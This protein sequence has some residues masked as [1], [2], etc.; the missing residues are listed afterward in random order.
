MYNDNLINNN[1]NG[2]YMNSRLK[3][4][5]YVVILLFLIILISLFNIMI[6]RH[7]EY[8]NAFDSIVASEIQGS[9]A[10]RGR[11]YDRNNKLLVDNTGIKSIYYK[12]ELGTSYEIN[13]AH[14]LSLVLEL[15]YN[16]VTDSMLKDLYLTSKHDE[17][18]TEEEFRM[19]KERKITSSDITRL[20]RSRISKKELDKV[21]KKTAYIYYLMNN[22]YS[23]EDKLIKKNLTDN[24]YAVIYENIDDYKGI[25]LKMDFDRKYIY[26]DTLR[27]V[28]GNISKNSIP[29]ELKNYYLDKGYS[30]NDRVGI[31]GLEYYYDDYL[32][33]EKSIYKSIEGKLTE[34]K[35]EKQGNDLVLTIDINLQK[36][37]E[38]IIDNEIK[39]AKDEPNTEYFN[40]VFALICNTDGEIL[41]MVARIIIDGN[42][43]DYTSYFVTSSVTVGSVIKGASISV[44]YKYGVID[45]GS[46]LKDE[47][48]KLSGTGT[49]CSWNRNGLGYLNDIDALKLSSNVYQF[50]TA[51]MI[52]GYNYSYNGSFSLKNDVFLKYRSMFNAYGLGVSSGIDLP[53]EALGLKGTNDTSG[54]LLDFSIGQ[55]D[56]YTPLQLASYINTIANNGSRV[57]LFLGKK[58]KDGSGNILF[59]NKREVLN[60]IPLDIKY[61]NRIQQGFKSVLSYG[62]TGFGY[63]DLKYKGAG[64]TGTS[65]SFLDSDKDGIID[66][67]TITSTFAGYAPYD[68]PEISIVVITP[69]ISHVYGNSYLSSLNRRISNKISKKYFEIY[70]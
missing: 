70:K 48:I 34:I 6:I 8:R 59:E 64:K 24:E 51:M 69:D 26:D 4:I 2:G 43:Y 22:G 13:L 53:N 62:G 19:L 35:K 37:L 42:I 54:L 56:T 66:K 57:R 68:N 10:L 52:S 36:S 49:K 5:S 65:Q 60:S 39:K 21:D 1:N 23:Y 12:R 61:I 67:E 46:V 50:K 45:I 41:A 40:K 55:Y 16:L 32:K 58:A 28:F 63:I 20:K 11:I 7:K 38:E 27:G 18:I 15:D 9:T 29:Y 47:C 31:S 3:I 44:G 17:L 14:R 30:I 33:G 25:K